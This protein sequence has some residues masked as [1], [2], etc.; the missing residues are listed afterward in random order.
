M[1]DRLSMQSD[2]PA[3]AAVRHDRRLFLSGLAASASLLSA[4]SATG[5]GS[6]L[7]GTPAKSD[8]PG[9][10]ALLA[11]VSGRAPQLG[12]IMRNAA[13]LGGNTLSDTGEMAFFDSGD[14]P[15]TAATAARLAVAAGARM[16]VGPLFGAQV[17]AVSQ[18]VGSNVPVLTL[19]NDV[20]VA[21]GG[22][23]VLGV[24]PEQSAR[25]VL[26]FAARR[27]LNTV[28]V[29]V[30]PG[31]FGSRSAEAAALVG[32]GT[33]QTVLPPLIETDPAIAVAKLTKA[34]GGTLPKAVYLPGAGAELEALAS[35]FRGKTQVL[36]SS[37]WSSRDPGN[38]PALRDAWYAAPDPLAF[39]PFAVAYQEAHG[40]SAGILAGVAFD[41]VETARL[42]GR[43]REQ[44]ASGLT[45]DKGFSGVLGP[46][47][48]SGLGLCS[49][50]LAV[51][52]VGAGAITMIGSASA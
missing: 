39:E 26:T 21:G 33:G 3:R 36:G 41:G 18:V 19:S 38:L 40:S 51:L 52:N 29:V 45:R 20:S 47:K 9:R 7:E 31:A 15:E 46:F 32:K 28:G 27:G 42:L 25:A 48:F 6:I 44:S 10:A 13:T 12:Q 30:P 16:I 34:N 37:Q 11:P 17:A 35:A 23:F 24:T 8:G 4:C 14:T 43:I 50:G 49:R 5:V 1:T 22:V 2:V